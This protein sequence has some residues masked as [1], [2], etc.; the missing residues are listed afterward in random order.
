[1]AKAELGVGLIGFGLSGQVFHLPFI[2]S[3][4]QLV[5]RAVQS[6]RP[7]AVQQSAPE[8]AVVPDTGTLLARDDIDLVVI[9]APNELH[10]DLARQCL[11]ADRHVLVE[12][13][14]VTRSEQMDQLLALASV[15]QRHL[16]VYQNRRYDG[17]F[18]TLR[19][20]VN[21]RTLGTLRHLDTRFDRF[22]PEPRNRWREQAGV[23]TGIFWDLGPHL[24]DQVLT[25]LGRP[26]TVQA[27]IRALRP[28]SQAADWFEL[29]LDYG[30]LQVSAGSTP[31]EAGRMRR[32]NARFDEGSWQCWGLDPQEEALRA[33]EQPDA[34]GYPHAGRQIAWQFDQAGKM[35]ELRIQAGD[36]RGF[37][38]DLVS[39]I[40]DGGPPPV[41]ANEARDLIHLMAVLEESAR[42]GR[43]LGWDYQS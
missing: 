13:P 38:R 14:S 39:A 1:M 10:F 23:G 6:R 16:S 15:H 3:H 32:F 31:Y 2:R 7:D 4:P 33:G 22:R 43:T 9:T 21:Q 35:E 34:A 12:K 25:L 30:E 17:D 19:S 11:E 26:K 36:Y 28:G 18:V 8:A 27:D 41:P 42:S 20:L 40:L 29:R 5:L 37:Y 24:L